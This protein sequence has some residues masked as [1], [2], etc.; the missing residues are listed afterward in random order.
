MPHDG[1]RNGARQ[2]SDG[3]I[4]SANGPSAAPTVVVAGATGFVGRAVLE[5]LSPRLRVIGL[6]RRQV[7]DSEGNP[8]WRSCDL[9]S[10]KATTEA[11][12]GT[13]LAIYLVHSMQP[14]AR[15]TQGSFAD[16]D[17]L[18]ADNF[19]RA[20]E[21]AGV[22]R[23]LYVGGFIPDGDDLSPHLQSRYEVE[24]TLASRGTP[25]T[26]LRSGIIVGPGSASLWILV[27]LVR[28]L[29]I[30]VLPRWTRSR[31]QPIALADLIRAVQ[32][33]V[34]E[35]E[36][37]HGVFELGGPEILTYRELMQR[38]A[39]HLGRRRWMLDV[40]ALTPKLSTLWVVV[41]GSAPP[42]L[43]GPLVSS[44][45][46]DMCAQQNPLNDHLAPEATS[47]DDALELALVAGGRPVRPPSSVQ[48]S[49]E[50]RGRQRDARTV[51]SV[52]RLQAP[53]R[54]AVAVANEYLRYL[55]R[56]ARRVIRVETSLGP[57]RFFLAGTQRLLLELTHAPD[58]S[59]RDRQVFDV[60]GGLLVRGGTEG[61]RLEFRQVQG[62]DTI[63]AA[64]HDFPPALPW[65]IYQMTQALVHVAVMRGF[66]RHL[67][68]LP[69]IAPPGAPAS[70]AD[71]VRSAAGESR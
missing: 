69:H 65:R 10:L 56:A 60:T 63:I 55:P 62:S 57:V 47:L 1:N 3:A 50:E 49:P 13:D 70:P 68:G 5:A 18:L 37:W 19:A 15:M 25:L 66:A 71:P 16:L 33:V 27:N 38:V 7:A 40:R 21:A 4:R 64:V 11:L 31:T 12:R 14:S 17:L 51:R 54:D 22:R 35:P 34:A 44:L 9:F 23:I 41:F 53:G 45:R 39:R 43:V 36:R 28:R 2:R 29:P 6:T 48:L 58:R 46:H 26:A 32:L 42:S 20:A 30:M 8:S 52:Q 61:G 59:Q 67:A 24:R